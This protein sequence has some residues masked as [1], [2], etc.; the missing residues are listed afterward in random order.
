M[1]KKKSTRGRRAGQL[2][3]AHKTVHEEISAAWQKLTLTEQNKLTASGITPEV[4]EEWRHSRLASV[5][6]FPKEVQYAAFDLGKL[7]REYKK[8][9]SESRSYLEMNRRGVEIPLPYLPQG[10]RFTEPE[11]VQFLH[12]GGHDVIWVMQHLGYIDAFRLLSYLIQAAANNDTKFF[13]E[14]CRRVCCGVPLES[15]A[16]P[17]YSALIGLKKIYK[18]GRETE[19]SQQQE[20]LNPT[21]T[22]YLLF[23]KRTL[24]L[25]FPVLILPRSKRPP[26]T[27]AQVAEY[28]WVYGGVKIS[29]RALSRH[30]KTFEIPIASR[31]RPKNGT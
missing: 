4:Q 26:L 3:K 24:P 14:F 8:I 1:R 21:M 7:V 13:K 29:N 22:P 17:L 11:L 10:D 2:T 5:G 12:E 16:E 25:L 31:G 19:G 23:L 30:A 18:S 20:K 27:L 28:V 9:L 15:P 6:N